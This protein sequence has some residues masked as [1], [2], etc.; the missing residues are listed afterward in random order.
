MIVLYW[1]KILESEQTKYI[2]HAYEWILTNIEHKPD[3]VNWA[4]KLGDIFFKLMQTTNEN[5][6]FN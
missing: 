3:C 6:L 2:E 5:I 4:S 1:F